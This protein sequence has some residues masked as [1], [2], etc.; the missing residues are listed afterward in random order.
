MS[1]EQSN[2]NIIRHI[3]ETFPNVIKYTDSW[4][5]LAKVHGYTQ[6]EIEKE[7]L[8][9]FANAM[10]LLTKRRIRNE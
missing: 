9:K 2:Q 3:R 4:L 8:L 1:N 6:S 10:S 7:T 5:Q